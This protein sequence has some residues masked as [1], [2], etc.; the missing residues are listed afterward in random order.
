VLGTP[1]EVR[2]ALTSGQAAALGD[3]SPETVQDDGMVATALRDLGG[4]VV[5][6]K[7]VLPEESPAGRSGPPAAG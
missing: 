7:P 5:D 4:Q 3:A 2:S 1:I 6:V